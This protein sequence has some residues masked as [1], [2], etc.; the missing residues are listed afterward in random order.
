[1]TFINDCV[2]SLMF[3]PVVMDTKT[4]LVTVIHMR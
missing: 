3:G 4:I 2:D 1:M